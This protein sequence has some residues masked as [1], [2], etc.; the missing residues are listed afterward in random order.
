M[1]VSNPKKIEDE[2]AIF[3]GCIMFRVCYNFVY[4][5]VQDDMN[6]LILIFLNRQAPSH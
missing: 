6:V 2:L 1:L 4:S 5:L 3:I